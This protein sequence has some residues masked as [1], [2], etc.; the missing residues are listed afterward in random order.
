MTLYAII[1]VYVVTKVSKNDPAA[2]VTIHDVR[3]VCG[4][5]F[6]EKKT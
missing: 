5:G 4:E 6:T 2:F 3:E 1:A